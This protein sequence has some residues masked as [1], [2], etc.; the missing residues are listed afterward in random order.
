M[1]ELSTRRA[2]GSNNLKIDMKRLTLLLL[3][4]VP[5]FA[6]AQINTRVEVSKAYVPDVDPA[7]KPAIVPD[8]TD[9]VRLRPDI[10]Y[11]ITPSV[12]SAPFAVRPFEPSRISYWEIDRP[13]PFYLK[14]GVG[15]PLRSVVDF[16]AS[17]QHPDVGYAAGWLNH[18]GFYGKIRDLAGKRE[19]A[20]R[21]HNR[22][23]GAAGHYFGRHLL[24]GRLEGGLQTFRRYGAIDPLSDYGVGDPVRYADAGMKVRFGDDF[25]NLEKF[26]F[27]VSAAVDYFNG[28]SKGIVEGK[29]GQWGVDFG[30]RLGRRFGRHDL[31][32]NAGY[33]FCRFRPDAGFDNYRMRRLDLGIRY[34]FM[35]RAIDFCAGLDYVYTTTIDVVPAEYN[36]YVLPWARIRFK[37]IGDGLVPFIEVDGTVERNDYG[38]LARVNP[39]VQAGLFSA[40]PTVDYNLRGGFAGSLREGRFAYSLRIEIKWQE[41][42]RY[43]YLTG[44]LPADDDAQAIYTGNPLWYSMVADRRTIS[45]LVFDLH[46]RTLSGFYTDARVRGSLLDDRGMIGDEWIGG[47][48]PQLEASCTVGLKRRKFEVAASVDIESVRCWSALQQSSSP[49]KPTV[50]TRLRVPITCNLSLR[51]DWHFS[52]ALTLFAEGDNL[53]NA[54]LFRWGAYPEPGIGFTAGVKMT[55]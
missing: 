47:G 50:L 28:R 6:A 25:N 35:V 32:L 17:T 7:A 30:V 15:L 1:T 13:D 45:S 29:N 16:H 44:V 49:E 42:A 52:H 22:L 55:F 5:M 20:T 43:W 8:R 23:G 24:E 14:A 18:D 36:H 46:W 21:T 34:D 19:R 40:K 10:D 12:Y 26:N 33:G 39:Y 27:D 4:A 53:A 11:S 9:T 38:S 41:N 54:R 3:L 31:V 48:V 51:A 2:N 37:S